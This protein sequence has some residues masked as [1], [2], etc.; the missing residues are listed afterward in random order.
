VAI[1][2]LALVLLR[3]GS[4]G[5]GGVCSLTL[6]FLASKEGRLPS[7]LDDEK[8]FALGFER[9]GGSSN[10]ACEACGV[11]VSDMKLVEV[12]LG[13]ETGAVR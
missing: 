7:N 11:V 2:V 1:L 3:W 6:P 12:L 13:G 4:C 10:D 8:P 5:G 9:L